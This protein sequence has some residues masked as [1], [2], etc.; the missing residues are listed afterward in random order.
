MCDYMSDIDSLYYRKS[1]QEQKIKDSESKIAGYENKIQRLEEYK[2][3]VATYKNQ[4]NTEFLKYL[5]EKDINNLSAPLNELWKGDMYTEIV[6]KYVWHLDCE[7]ESFYK[8]IDDLLDDV[9]DEINR[10]KG[11]VYNEEGIIGSIKNII[12]DISNEIEKFCN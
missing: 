6:D 4:F 7:I 5:N 9:C 10:L 1:Q 2:K 8:K 11:K 12:A 3:K